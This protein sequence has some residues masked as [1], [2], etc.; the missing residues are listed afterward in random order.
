MELDLYSVQR[1]GLWTE[2]DSKGLTEESED[3]DEDEAAAALLTKPPRLHPCE[4]EVE[5]ELRDA[6]IVLWSFSPSVRRTQRSR[7][8]SEEDDVSE[9]SEQNVAVRFLQ[10]L[11]LACW[12]LRI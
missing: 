11:L 2:G 9:D 4:V 12:G 10:T 1:V 7:F 8:G 6:S 5:V 3:E